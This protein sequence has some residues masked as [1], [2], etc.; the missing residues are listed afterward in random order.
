[1]NLP[2]SPT[3]YSVDVGIMAVRC[4][5]DVVLNGPFVAEF[6][7]LFKG[8]CMEEGRWSW[9]ALLKLSARCPFVVFAGVV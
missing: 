3:G 9:W 4:G 8:S 2:T 1:M 7:G 5:L 6:A